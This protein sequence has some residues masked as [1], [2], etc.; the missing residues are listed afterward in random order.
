MSQEYEIVIVDGPH[1]GHEESVKPHMPDIWLM[2]SKRGIC[3]YRVKL[4]SFGAMVKTKKFGGKVC[5][6]LWRPGR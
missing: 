6:S 4:D 2:D 3:R 1:Q 5:Y